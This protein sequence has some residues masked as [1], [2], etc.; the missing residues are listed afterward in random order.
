MSV[1]RELTLRA[2]GDDYVLEQRPVHELAGRLRVAR[3]TADTHEAVHGSAAQVSVAVEADR[4]A[5]VV[6][7][8]SGADA[9]I[10]IDR[11]NGVLTVEIPHA[12]AGYGPATGLVRRAALPPIDID[13]V[14]V[15]DAA[16]IEVF[17]GPATVT[18]G[19]ALDPGP[20]TLASVGSLD[21]DRASL[22]A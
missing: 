7:S 5:R 13:L 21:G 9:V 2:V 3:F 11:A 8:R 18:D 22:E 15:V 12:V 19:L 4:D 1:P 20:W 10:A 17:A 14:V 16:S 6:A